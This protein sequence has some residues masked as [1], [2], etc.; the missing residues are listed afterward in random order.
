MRRV[1]YEAAA[2]HIGIV[3]GTLRSLVSRRQVPHIRISPQLVIFDLDELDAWLAEKRVAAE[4]SVRIAGSKAKRKAK[5]V[6]S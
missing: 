6:A 3:P 2:Q 5:A 1:G 4:T